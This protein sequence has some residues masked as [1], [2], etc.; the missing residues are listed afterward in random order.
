V[1]EL[2]VPAPSACPICEGDGYRWR[3][4]FA[5]DIC[6]DCRCV[7]CGARTGVIG[8]ECGRCHTDNDYQAKVT[9]GSRT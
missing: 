1:A 8:G 3:G 7:I 5:V 2:Q 9:E 4:V 6:R